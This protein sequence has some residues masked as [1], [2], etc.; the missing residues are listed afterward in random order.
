MAKSIDV[1]AP[2]IY[3]SDFE[4]VCK[5]YATEGNH[6]LLPRQGETGNSYAMLL[7]FWEIWGNWFFAFW[8]R[9]SYGRYTPK[10]G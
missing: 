10:T 2:D 8:D 4:G 7:C 1:F 5:E 6:C 9:M 3:L